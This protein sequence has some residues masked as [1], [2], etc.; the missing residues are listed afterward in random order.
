MSPATSE[1]QRKLMC[2]A[3]SIK[4]GLTPA[5]RSPEAAKIAAQMS[6]EQLKDFCKSED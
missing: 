3:L 5:S 6:E 4:Q 2:L 1:S